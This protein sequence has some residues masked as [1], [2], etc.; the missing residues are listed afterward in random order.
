LII[1]KLACED[2]LQTFA[3]HIGSQR[4]LNLAKAALELAIEQDE[5]AANK[6]L[7]DN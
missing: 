1:N 7:Y 6:L 3:L 2:V 5:A 4:L